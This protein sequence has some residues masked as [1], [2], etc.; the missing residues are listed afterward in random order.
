M[1]L[2]MLW[3]WSV[4]V[5]VFGSLVCWISSLTH[6]RF[7][8]S[9]CSVGYSVCSSNGASIGDGS[10]LV[11]FIQSSTVSF[12][13]LPLLFSLTHFRFS[14]SSCSHGNF[15]CSKNSGDV[16]DFSWWVLWSL[17]V[18]QYHL[19][20]FLCCISSS[21]HFRFFSSLSCSDGVHSCLLN[22]G[23]IAEGAWL[24]LEQAWEHSASAWMW[25]LSIISSAQH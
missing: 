4:K 14:S 10:W 5:V 13:L 11:M 18:L 22:S 16:G 25:I 8:S 19:V 2:G 1:G 17:K 23:N 15:A 9:S 7:S 24:V 3:L 6:F 20:F 21:T 12:G